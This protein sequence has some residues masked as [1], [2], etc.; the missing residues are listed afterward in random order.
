VPDERDGANRAPDAYEAKYMQADGDALYR[1]KSKAPWWVHLLFLSPVA[2]VW[3]VYAIGGSKPAP[4]YVPLLLTPLLTLIWL[5]FSVLRVTVTRK[6]LVVQYG[7]FGPTIPIDAIISH[8]EV[9]Y[10]VSKTSYGIHKTSD[11]SWVYNMF[12][13]GAHGVKVVYRQDGKQ[14]SVLLGTP[15]AARIASALT[16]A[17]Q[18]LRVPAPALALS[19]TAESSAESSAESGAELEAEAEAAEHAAAE[20]R[21]HQ[22]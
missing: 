19:P 10:D 18:R 2:F 11:G 1:D 9:D 13:D 12:G 21:K 6:N 14:K 3:F 7:L 22:G 8:E 16:A 17:R 4:L 20:A 15:G 5:L